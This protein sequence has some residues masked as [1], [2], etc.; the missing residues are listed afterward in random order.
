MAGSEFCVDESGLKLSKSVNFD[1]FGGF[2][3]ILHFRPDLYVFWMRP[4]GQK[5]LAKCREI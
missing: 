3:G 5:A 4:S 1:D 2:G